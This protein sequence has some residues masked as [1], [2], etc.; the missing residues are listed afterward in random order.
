MNHHSDDTD[1]EPVDQLTP[2]TPRWVKGFGIIFLILILLLVILH[3][4]GNRFRN[5]TGAGDAGGHTPP[6]EHRVQQ[7]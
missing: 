2:S 7:P 5:H 1:R 4:T 6:V 3:L